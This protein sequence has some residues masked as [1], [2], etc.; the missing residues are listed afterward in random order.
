MAVNLIKQQRDEGSS[1]MTVFASTRDLKPQSE[2]TKTELTK[3]VSAVVDGTVDKTVKRKK[4]REESS[5][6]RRRAVE[7]DNEDDDEEAGISISE[8][9]YVSDIWKKYPVQFITCKVYGD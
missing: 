8:V 9:R 7:E 4:R 3:E 5:E 6:R 1:D 2:E